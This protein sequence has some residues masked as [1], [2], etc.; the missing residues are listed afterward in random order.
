MITEILYTL[1]IFGYLG[2]VLIGLPLIPKYKKWIIYLQIFLC[3][4]KFIFL[5]LLALH[6]IL[7]CNEEMLWRSLKG[8]AVILMTL[9][10]VESL[11]LV[12]NKLG[13]ARKS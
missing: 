13:Y 5:S 7:W 1:I 6:I 9:G 2:I 10:E 8:L 12:K 11:K 4:L 3:F